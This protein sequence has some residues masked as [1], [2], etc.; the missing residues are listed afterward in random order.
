MSQVKGQLGVRFALAAMSAYDRADLDAEA[1][2]AT[3]ENL[4]GS[5]V[6]AHHGDMLWDGLNC[7]VL[8][9]CLGV[10]VH[11]AWCFGADAE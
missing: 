5:L 6:C 7:V 4:V 8:G 11:P 3:L 1:R 10:C 2:D 9:T